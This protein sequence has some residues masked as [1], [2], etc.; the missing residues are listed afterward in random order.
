MIRTQIQLSEEQWKKLKALS[1]ARRVSMA[2]LIRQSV[3]LLVHNPE[4]VSLEER[5]K[6][7]LEIA[8]KY[9]SGSSDIS[10]GHDQYLDKIYG[11]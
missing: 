7:A 11:S 5:R 10:N 6:K 8:G 2:E 1:V 9:R 3:D 4:A